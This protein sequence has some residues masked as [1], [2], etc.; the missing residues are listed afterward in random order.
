MK[1]KSWKDTIHGF[2]V[3]CKSKNIAWY[4]IHK[5]CVE[6]EI[7]VPPFYKVVK[8]NMRFYLVSFNGEGRGSVW[9]DYD[10]LPSRL[11][12]KEYITKTYP[13]V[14]TPIIMHIQELS[15]DDYNAFICT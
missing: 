1:D 7:E 5:K 13:R 14:K 2:T 9:L 12:I 4:L 6:L 15:K 8:V 10:G 11:V 3:T